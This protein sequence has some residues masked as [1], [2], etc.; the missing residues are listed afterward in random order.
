MHWQRGYLLVLLPLVFAMISLAFIRVQ[1]QE[2]NARA[3]AEI[4]TKMALVD[5]RAISVTI[6]RAGMLIERYAVNGDAKA[7][8]QCVQAIDDVNRHMSDVESALG[9]STGRAKPLASI[10]Q[11]V[12]RCVVIL[13]SGLEVADAG[14][15]D[16][17]ILS[18]TFADRTMESIMAVGYDINKLFVDDADLA[19]TQSAGL[20]QADCNVD[21]AL[22]FGLL[23]NLAV[24]AA[25]M[26]YFKRDSVGHS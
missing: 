21:I 9:Q 24:A 5:S 20:K 7:R 3:E 26:I 23:C 14:R 15:P 1:V 25:L 2:V 10:K 12:Q 18:G 11:S 4:K 8:A 22:C 6:W 17:S 19:A 13:K 16:W